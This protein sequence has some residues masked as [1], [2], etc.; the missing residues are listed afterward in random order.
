MKEDEDRAVA[1]G[2]GL[3]K[4]VGRAEEENEK[5]SVQ[6][7]VFNLRLNFRFLRVFS[8][9]L[10]VLICYSS[11]PRSGLF[12]QEFESLFFRVVDL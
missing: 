4:G 1:C 8:L 9:A 7:L 12:F 11:N 3:T 6:E 2:R 5:K 10:R